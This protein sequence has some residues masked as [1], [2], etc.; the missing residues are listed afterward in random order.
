M[1][2]ISVFVVSFV[3]KSTW[4]LHGVVAN[5]IKFDI[6]VSKFEFQSRYCIHFRANTFGKGIIPLYPQ[7]GAK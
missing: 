1:S 2:Q 4:S 6:L 5:V 3:I 7:L